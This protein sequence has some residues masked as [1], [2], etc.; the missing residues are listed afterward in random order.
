[1]PTSSPELLGAAQHLLLNELTRSPATLVD[2][3][4]KLAQQARD[5]DTGTFKVR[6]YLP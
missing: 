3:V 6:P 5:L 1:V 4:L 2:A